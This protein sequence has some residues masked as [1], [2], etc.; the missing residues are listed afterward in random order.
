MPLNC[1]DLVDNTRHI[2]HCKRHSAGT[3]MGMF[4]KSND[5]AAALIDNTTDKNVRSYRMTISPE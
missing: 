5:L 1:T 2:D 4:Y 3:P